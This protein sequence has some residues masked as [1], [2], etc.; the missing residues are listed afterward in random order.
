MVVKAGSTDLTTV[1][2]MISKSTVL[3]GKTTG[4]PPTSSVTCEVFCT[5]LLIK[6]S[7]KFSI[8]YTTVYDF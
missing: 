4:S 2:P 1:G 5:M 3:L 7:Q 8:V 6:Y